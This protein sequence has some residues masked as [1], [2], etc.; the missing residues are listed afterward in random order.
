MQVIYKVEQLAHME[1]LTNFLDNPLGG[2]NT[3]MSGYACQWCDFVPDEEEEDLTNQQK[4][5][6]LTS[7]QRANHPDEMRARM[8]ANKGKAAAKQAGNKEATRRSETA[9]PSE[10][11]DGAVKVRLTSEQITLPGELFVLFHW[12]KTLF[13]EYEA[14]KGEWLQHVVATWAIDHG[15]EIR[16]PS[17]PGVFINNALDLEP[18]DEEIDEDEEVEDAET[19]E[20]NPMAAW[21]TRG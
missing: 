14:T 18:E 19:E 4:F 1:V 7:H 3:I 8:N 16:L 12:V 17:I 2:Y 10:M 9:S 13:P 20:L 5:A 11:A 6:V 15:D 21:Y